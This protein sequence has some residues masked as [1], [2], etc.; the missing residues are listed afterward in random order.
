MKSFAICNKRAIP[1]RAPSI[2]RLYIS[3]AKW[4]KKN[5]KKYKNKLKELQ[6]NKT[7]NENEIE[8]ELE[9]GKLINYQ[10]CLIQNSASVIY[11]LHTYIHI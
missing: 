5:T 6:L 11:I 9:N 1:P 3:T 10:L 4:K 2:C 7:E 8:I